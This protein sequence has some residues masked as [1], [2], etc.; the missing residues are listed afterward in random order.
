[1]IKSPESVE[2][3]DVRGT[4]YFDLRTAKPVEIIFAFLSK[5][6][7]IACNFIEFTNLILVIKKLAEGKNEIVSVSPWELM[8]RVEKEKEGVEVVRCMI[9]VDRLKLG[10]DAEE[11]N[12]FIFVVR[13]LRGLITGT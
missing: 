5:N 8:R 10:I 7:E 1:M 2:Q 3:G 4:C 6:L 9:T 13:R 11:F 12:N